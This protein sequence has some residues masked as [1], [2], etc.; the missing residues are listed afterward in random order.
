MATRLEK[1]SG[2]LLAIVA[3]IWAAYLLVDM[4]EFHAAYL[5]LGPMQL[6]MAGILLWL[7]GKYRASP[8]PHRDIGV[9][10][11]LKKTT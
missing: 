11:H 4:S 8:S 6:L 2:W 3:V 5:R 7:H 9:S 1:Q 10:E